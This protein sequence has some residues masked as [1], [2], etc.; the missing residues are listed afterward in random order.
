MYM[1]LTI[2]KELFL[3]DSDYFRRSNVSIVFH[4]HGKRT[5]FLV[6]HALIFSTASD[7]FIV[8]LNL[9]YKLKRCITQIFSSTKIVLFPSKLM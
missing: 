2:T 5:V 6:L 9:L 8:S 7:I 1:T 3:L 4:S